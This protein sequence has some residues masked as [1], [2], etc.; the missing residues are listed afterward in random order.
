MTFPGTDIY[1]GEDVYPSALG[2]G[3][4]TRRQPAQLLRLGGQAVVAAYLGDLLIWDGTISA[5][6][7]APKATASALGLAPLVQSQP[8]T[9]TVPT[10]TATAAALAPMIG[11]SSTI[12]APIATATAAASNLVVSADAN[13]TVPIATASAAAIAPLSDA[14]LVIPTATA[15]AQAHVPVIGTTGSFNVGIPT[16][17]ASAAALQPAVAVSATIAPPVATASGAALAPVVSRGA[18]ITPPVAAATA[19]ATAPVVAVAVFAPSGMSKN[20]TQTWQTSATWIPITSWTANTGTYPGSSVASDRLVVQGSKTN[21]TISASIPFSGGIFSSAHTV[22]LV[23]QSGT[24]IATGAAVNA[25][26]GTCT[27][28]ANNVN[29]TGITSIGVQM[30]SGGSNAGNVSSGSSCLLTI[31]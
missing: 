28:T 7:N 6:V 12:T 21:A 17:I 30:N 11:V 9:I 23:T 8:P 16:A 25:N 26:S 20:G 22:R 31:T 10:A 15:T 19:A 13:I 2:G 5:F 27:V 1:P 24:V 29:L 3:I 18:T 14:A 4:F